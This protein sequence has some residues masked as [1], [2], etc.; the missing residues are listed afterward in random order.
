MLIEFIYQTIC[1][2]F[3]T[4]LWKEKIC[5]LL[6]CSL[7]KDSCVFSRGK[8]CLKNKGS[9]KLFYIFVLE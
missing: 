8:K 5:L 4:Y 7:V 6:F 3:F 2:S 1:L 9:F